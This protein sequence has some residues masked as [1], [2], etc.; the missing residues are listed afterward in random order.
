MLGDKHD[1][2]QNCSDGTI[3]GYGHLRLN[4]AKILLGQNDKRYS[5]MPALKTALTPAINV[6]Y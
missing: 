1:I 2:L 5:D 4:E 6:I 3:T